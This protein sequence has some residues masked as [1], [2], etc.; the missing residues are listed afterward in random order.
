LTSPLT[1]TGT[2]AQCNAEF[3]AMSVLA[4]MS[5]PGTP[6]IY[7]A[8]PTVADMRTGA[9]APGAI[10]TGML[11]MGCA[12]MARYYNV[13]CGGYVGLTNSKVNDAQS[14]FETGMSTLA[15][16][17]AGMDLLNVGGL[18]DALM[19]FDFAKAVIDNE[20]GLML[21]RLKRGFEF[22]RENLALEVIAEVGPGGIFI[23]KQ[24]T[25]EHMRTTAL[26]PEIADRDTRGQWQAK[27]ALDAHARA[28]RR[29]REILTRDNPAVFSP[30]VD[31]RIR[32]EFE[33][34]VAGDA[35]LEWPAA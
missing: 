24:H 34:L 23:D 29:V 6:L 4:Q 3:L 12:Q 13:P 15:A 22:S 17:L 1:L 35:V 7:A 25:L 18:L 14:G 30:D 2:L 33:G 16:T 31:A 20:I 21:K 28:M 5:R 9:Y 27:G 19:T 26:L 11:M 8:L 10:E 32:A